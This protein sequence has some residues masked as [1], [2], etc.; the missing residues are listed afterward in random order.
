MPI[1]IFYH[2]DDGATFA[3]TL[4][5]DLKAHLGV[6]VPT[7]DAGN[8]H[9]VQRGDLV[10]VV[11][12]P[13]AYG[14]AF[15]RYGRDESERRGAF[16]Y[17]ITPDDHGLTYARHLASR[18]LA[19][20]GSSRA[21]PET[22]ST[23]G[24]SPDAFDQ[25]RGGSGGELEAEAPPDRKRGDSKEAQS[26]PPPP[27]PVPAPAVVP[28]PQPIAP[29]PS[30]PAAPIQFSAYYPME[31]KP[32]EWQPLRAYVYKESAAKDVERDVQKELADIIDRVRQIAEAAR[33]AISDGALIT[34][35]PQLDGFQFNPPT[36]AIAFYEDW[37]RFDFKLRAHTAKPYSAVNG[38]ITFKVE[39]IIVADLPLSIFV[40]PQAGA[41]LSGGQTAT[42]AKPY[43]AIFCSY[44]HKDT[45]IILRV[46]RAIKTLGD[47]FLR[48]AVTL[49]SGEDW[50]AG[51]LAMIDRA[52]VFQLFW[53]SSAAASKYV[54]QEWEYA[55]AKMQRQRIASFI[56]PV[57]WEDQMPPPPPELGHLHFAHDPTLDD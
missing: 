1:F 55:L 28:S 43:R 27:A 32:N 2:P 15:I 17:L 56:R 53:S 54:R 14:S 20:W 19:D 11:A 16:V 23:R 29:A 44:S 30:A 31:L 9:D 37:Q 21:E 48:D 34:A 25:L 45:P 7:T 42:T 18:H 40:S 57:Y 35:E 24:L 10:L 47:D 4:H 8:V 52:D 41:T 22:D 5:F 13:L 38:R 36:A 6:D 26:A 33:G 12:T 50:N 39:G 49:R 51:L 3:R 46:E